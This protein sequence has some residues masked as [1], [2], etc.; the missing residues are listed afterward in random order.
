[1]DINYSN[2]DS[3]FRLSSMRKLGRYG[4]SSQDE[5]ETQDKGLGNTGF[6]EEIKEQDEIDFGDPEEE[7][8]QNSVEKARSFKMQD[9]SKSSFR[10]GDKVLNY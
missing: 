10:E 7:Q 5:I 6:D 8:E 4:Q 3:A 1:M 2:N 9:R